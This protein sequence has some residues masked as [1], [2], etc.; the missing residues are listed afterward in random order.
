MADH[1]AR[2]DQRY[3]GDI[4]N[5]GKIKAYVLWDQIRMLM[6]R[7]TQTLFADSSTGVFEIDNALQ[8]QVQAQP[9][10]SMAAVF[11]TRMRA[12]ST[13]SRAGT[14]SRAAS[15]TSRRRS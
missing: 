8:A 3:R 2:D 5:P 9:R 14:S 15:S 10:A 13:P 1:V 7:T 4:V 6:S 12:H 11:P